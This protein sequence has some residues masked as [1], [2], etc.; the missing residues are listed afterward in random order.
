[1]VGV[2]HG[3]GKPV[4]CA[5]AGLSCSLLIIISPS[6]SIIALGGFSHLLHLISSRPGLTRHT[7][8]IASASEKFLE[9]MLVGIL[10]GS[11]IQHAVNSV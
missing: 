9:F 11:R 6:L 10:D 2:V 8:V 4:H 1:M 7:P 3:N 5:F